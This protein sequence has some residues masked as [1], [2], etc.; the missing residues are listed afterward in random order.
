V[1]AQDA[2]G[3]AFTAECPRRPIEDRHVGERQALLAVIDVVRKRVPV[4]AQ[5]DPGV[6][7]PDHRELVRR[8]IGQRPQQH[9][10]RD[11][12][13]RA[14]RADAQREREDR[15]DREGRTTAQHASRI[16]D[17]AK[18]GFEVEAHLSSCFVPQFLVRSSK[19]KV[20]VAAFFSNLLDGQWRVVDGVTASRK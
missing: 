6:V 19:F 2:L 16:A 3:I 9:T 12:E 14:V 11:A 18:K 8:G 10:A 7:H 13:N 17:V 1:C 15:R 4:L 20:Q 5:V